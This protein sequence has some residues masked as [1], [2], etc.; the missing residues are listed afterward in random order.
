MW[1]LCLPLFSPVSLPLFH[2]FV[3]WVFRSP[4]LWFLLCVFF[5]FCLR[6]LPFSLVCRGRLKTMI[7]VLVFWVYC[8]YWSLFYGFL[9]SVSPSF[10]FVPSLSV[11][12]FLLSFPHRFTPLFFYKARTGGNGRL[13]WVSVAANGWKA[14][15]FNGRAVA[16]E[17]DG[18]QSLKTTLFSSSKGCFQFGPWNS[19]NFAIKP[20]V[21]T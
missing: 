1:F 6:V 8:L 5:C 19:Y 20:L 14:S 13:Q 17:E 4:P 18:E 7:L 15:A 21:K 12:L 16:E 2:L 9:S 3:F 11:S 10:S